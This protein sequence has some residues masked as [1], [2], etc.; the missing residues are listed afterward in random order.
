MA[1]HTWV[2]GNDLS[3][4]RAVTFQKLQWSPAALDSGTPRQNYIG[5]LDVGGK[6]ATQDFEQDKIGLRDDV[7]WSLHL[8]GRS[9]P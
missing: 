9:T 6:D 3:T 7:S 8:A 5:I 2:L 4:R 1:K